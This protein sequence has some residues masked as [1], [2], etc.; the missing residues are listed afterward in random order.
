[1]LT[2]TSNHGQSIDQVFEL[3]DVSS[4][5]A[6]SREFQAGLGTAD[7]FSVPPMGVLNELSQ[8]GLIL[9]SKLVLP[10]GLRCEITLL[11]ELRN[12][13]QSDF[14]VSDYFLT[15]SAVGT[16]I[17]GDLMLEKGALFQ[18]AA[19]GIGDVTVT[20][21]TLP[22]ELIKLL[23]DEMLRQHSEVAQAIEA[24]KTSDKP[25]RL[26]KAGKVIEELGRCLGHL[27]NTAGALAAIALITRV[28]SGSGL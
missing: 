17:Y 14:D 2:F 22:D 24:L 15:T 21:E 8:F 4:G 18:S 7:G 19:A 1:M 13:V 12:A 16:I 10:K 25:T 5:N 6:R 26:Q 27:T 23:G 20:A 28:L 9:M 11:Q 3:I